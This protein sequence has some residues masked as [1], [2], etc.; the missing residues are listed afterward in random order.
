MATAKKEVDLDNITTD[1]VEA[2][3]SEENEVKQKFVSWDKIGMTIQGYYVDR[4][5]TPNRLKP[6]TDQALYTIMQKDGTSIIVAGRYGQPV[7]TFPGFE[8]TPLGS[9]VG[10]KYEG[11]REA[12]KKGFNPTKIIRTY[13]KRG[14]DGSPVLF[15]DMLAKFKG[16]AMEE[17]ASDH[18]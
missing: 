6:G 4:R 12:T 13:V 3:F 17:T 10:F 16:E 1:D 9:M 5:V 15:P 8:Q 2:L 7:Q 14:K 18:F 11:D